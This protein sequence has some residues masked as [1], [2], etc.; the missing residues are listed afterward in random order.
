M[1][2][3]FPKPRAFKVFTTSDKHPRKR[4]IIKRKQEDVNSQKN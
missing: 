3:L 1:I 2:A 4:I